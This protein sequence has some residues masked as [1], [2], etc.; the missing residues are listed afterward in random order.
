MLRL[1]E[2]VFFC[3]AGDLEHGVLATRLYAF[4]FY[5][6]T[7][8]VHIDIVAPTESVTPTECVTHTERIVSTS[9]VPYWKVGNEQGCRHSP[10]E[11]VGSFCM[12]DDV[13]K[14]RSN[15]DVYIRHDNGVCIR[16]SDEPSD[17]DGWPSASM[18][19]CHCAD[20]VRIRQTLV[21]LLDKALPT[22]HNV[23]R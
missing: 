14:K 16:D 2:C 17:Y 7:G 9:K 10:E 21:M 8:Q 19:V 15:H 18:L 23:L 22:I 6:W 3:D 5:G 1:N 12:I 4:M 20:D 11:Y 13:S